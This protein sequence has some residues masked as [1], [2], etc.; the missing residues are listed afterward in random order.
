MIETRVSADNTLSSNFEYQP[1]VL[2]RFDLICG[3][4]IMIEVT[5]AH[6]VKRI[7][8]QV[9]KAMNIDR[10]KEFQEHCL[11]TLNTRQTWSRNPRISSRILPYYLIKENSDKEYLQTAL[12]PKGTVY[13]I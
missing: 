2:G 7:S 12:L 6:N 4:R 10:L 1:T 13:F 3:M 11:K 9:P 5:Y 8:V